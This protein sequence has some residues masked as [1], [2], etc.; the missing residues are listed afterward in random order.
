MIAGQYP[1]GFEIGTHFLNSTQKE[2]LIMKDCQI[3]F[4]YKWVLLFIKRYVKR[5]EKQIPQKGENTCHTDIHRIPI[6][7]IL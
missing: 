6:Q 5:L 4:Y 1:A 7:W 3:S 2:S